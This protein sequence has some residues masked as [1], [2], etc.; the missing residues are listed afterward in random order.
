MS[1]SPSA[2]ASTSELAGPAAVLAARGLA[3]RRGDRIL[4]AGFDLEIHPGQIVWLRGTNGRGKTSLL[5]LLAGLSR[6]EQGGIT[7][8]GTPIR[9]AEDFHRRLVYVGH[10]NALKDDLTAME[11]LRFLALLH[12]RAAARPALLEALRRCGVQAQRDAPVRTLSQGQRR[13]VALA[14]L[15]LESEA[16]LWI[17]DE[18]FD[19]LDT[20][21]VD[22]LNGLLTDHA[23]RGGCVVLTSHL[24]LTLTD[25]QPLTV[26]LDNVAA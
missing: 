5:R 1:S 11:S 19:A 21:G 10:S 23:R 9:A 15:C 3:C 7:W 4:F 12:G 26:S 17:L 25:P 8:H 20:Q 13:R 2:D 14:R 16:S 6:P 24:A 18:P 22:V